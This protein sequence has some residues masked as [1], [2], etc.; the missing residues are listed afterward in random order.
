M[1]WSCAEVEEKGSAVH[2][3]KAA[4]VETV[5]EDGRKTSVVGKFA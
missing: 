2:K 1:P 3:A 5:G 4:G